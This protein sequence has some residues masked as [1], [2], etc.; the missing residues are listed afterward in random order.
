MKSIEVIPASCPLVKGC[1][2]QSFAE[3]KKI[4]LPLHLKWHTIQHLQSRNYVDSISAVGSSQHHSCLILISP[5]H[6]PMTSC[7]FPSTS[8]FRKRIFFWLVFSFSSFFF[9]LVWQEMTEPEMTAL[10]RTY[11]CLPILDP[12]SVALPEVSSIFSSLKFFFLGGGVVF[13]HPNWESKDRGCSILQ[14]VLQI[15]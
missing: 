12:S 8:M 2:E 13:P 3:E 11:A 7:H 5:S 9:S 1:S 6:L 15:W 4:I 14:I 10:V